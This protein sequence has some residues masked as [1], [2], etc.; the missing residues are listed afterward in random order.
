[1]ACELEIENNTHEIGIQ[2]DDKE[3]SEI[4]VQVYNNMSYTLDSYIRQLQAQ[5]NIKI[6]EIEDHKK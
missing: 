3:T 1:H 2:T 6:N 4:G 5:L